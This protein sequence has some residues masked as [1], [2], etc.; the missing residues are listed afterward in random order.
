MSSGA[1]LV[2]GGLRAVLLRQYREQPVGNVGGD[3]GV[4][5]LLMTRA[6]TASDFLLL[7]SSNPLRLRDSEVA[8]NIS[9]ADLPVWKRVMRSIA[10]I[11]NPRGIGW[12]CR[13][14]YAVVPAQGHKSRGAFIRA[15]ILRFLVLYL[16][17]DAKESIQHLT[18]NFQNIMDAKPGTPPLLE[19]NF[20]TRFM[21]I[22]WWA[23]SA[24]SILDIQL[25]TLSMVSV[26]L[27]V[28][29]P[30]DWPNVMGDIRDAW[31]IQQ[32]WGCADANMA[33]SIC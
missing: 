18:P 28:S 2:C 23:V 27:G 22:F 13:V 15:R 12:N 16:L 26:A 6:I 29:E 11:W 30:K 10:L 1:Q 19:Q 33:H 5:G 31:S 9:P 21:V 25:V 4:G 7:E 20:K 32:A 17:L 14:P 24:F 8:N 3:W